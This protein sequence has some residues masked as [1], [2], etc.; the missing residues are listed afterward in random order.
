MRQHKPVTI[1]P[2]NG[3]RLLPDLAK[4]APDLANYA[5]KINWRRRLDQEITREGDVEFRPNMDID[6]GN[7][8]FPDYLYGEPVTFLHTARRPNGTAAMIAGT[9]NRLYRYY[10]LSNGAI[11]DEV[12][13]G[14]TVYDADVFDP[15]QGEWILIG[16]GFSNSG[17]RWEGVNTNGYAVFNN[18]ADLPVT[19]RLEEVTVKPIYELREQGVA[20]VGTISEFAGSLLLADV[21]EIQANHLED[22]LTGP[23]PYALFDDTNKINRRGYRIIY[24][25]AGEPRRWGPTYSGSIAEGGRTLTLNYAPKSVTVGSTLLI[26]G[27]GPSG[28]SLSVTVRSVVDNTVSFLEI[29]DNTVSDTLVYHEDTLSLGPSPGAYDLQD[30]GTRIRRLTTLQNVIVAMKDTSIFMGAPTGSSDNPFDFRPAY[31]GRNSIFWPWLM[32]NDGQ[33]LRYGGRDGFYS[34]DLTTRVPKLI[35]DLEA[36]EKQFFSDL[37]ETED[38]DKV[39]ATYNRLT[40]EHWFCRP[41]QTLCLDLEQGTVSRTDLDLS[42]A[43]TIVRP[44]AGGSTVQPPQDWFAYSDRYGKIRQYGLADTA[45][46]QF[47]GERSVHT[48]VDGPNTSFLETGWG[49]FNDFFD[50]GHLK[51]LLPHF[52]SAASQFELILFG[53]RDPDVIVDPYTPFAIAEDVFADDVFEDSQALFARINLDEEGRTIPT[54]YEFHYY[55]LFLVVRD[56]EASFRGSSWEF[57]RTRDRAISKVQ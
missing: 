6:L 32:A 14:S 47:S 36:N 4:E 41:G 44:V 37:D 53:S 20:A 27:A 11:Y 26:D 51:S 12:E 50:S 48:R 29:A 9:Q 16:D 57:S 52:R 18:G 8:D 30:D 25:P 45:L 13:G 21:S 55:K 10:A 2:V 28:A 35:P 38:I 5:S 42:A 3:G 24:S 34:F 54:H 1:R 39:F 46:D 17:H 7:Q 40:Q 22:V 31:H 19:Y 49:A 43:A 23:N 15:T 33:F 56:A